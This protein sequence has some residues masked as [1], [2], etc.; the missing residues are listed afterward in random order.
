MSENW[1]PI[2]GFEGKYDVSDHGRV[3]SRERVVHF[4]PTHSAVRR[5]RILKQVTV[6]KR[7]VPSVQLSDGPG[8]KKMHKVHRLVALAFLG[9][10]TDDGADVL[11]LDDNPA[12]NRLE[13]LRYGDDRANALDRVRNGRDF[14]ANK[15]HC[16]S[17]HEY[18]PENTYRSPKH[19]HRSC[20]TCRQLV[21]AQRTDRRKVRVAS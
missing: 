19:G 8:N 17:G 6:G 9:A 12:N 11:H 5:G 10:P 21:D 20:K 4:S 13:N 3:Y 18:T 1:L 16:V 15:T 7:G 2:P 14:N